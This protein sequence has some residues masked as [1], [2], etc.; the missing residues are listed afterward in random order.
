MQGYENNC[1]NNCFHK[2]NEAMKSN[3]FRKMNEEIFV[4]CDDLIN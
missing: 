4:L 1:E 2:M 3:C